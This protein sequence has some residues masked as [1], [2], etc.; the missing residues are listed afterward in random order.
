MTMIE[1]LDKLAELNNYRVILVET[2]TE[3]PLTIESAIED[4]RRSAKDVHEIFD[5]MV[6]EDEIRELDENGCIKIGEP[7]YRVRWVPE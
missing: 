1:A 6:T 5:L 4:F 2:N 7:L 3:E